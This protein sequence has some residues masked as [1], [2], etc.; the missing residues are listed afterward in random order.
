MNELDKSGGRKELRGMDERKDVSI[1]DLD[2]DA[3]SVRWKHTKMLFQLSGE[4]EQRVL[5]PR[6]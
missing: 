2:T 1:G 6:L 5:Y 3:E 4:A